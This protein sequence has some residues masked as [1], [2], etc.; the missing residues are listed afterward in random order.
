MTVFIRSKLKLFIYKKLNSSFTCFFYD[1]ALGSSSELLK[2][3][4]KLYDSL[5]SKLQ[6]VLTL[7]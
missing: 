7:S 1:I 6:N 2:Y 3:M 5:C 4:L